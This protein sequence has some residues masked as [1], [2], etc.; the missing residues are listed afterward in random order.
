MKVLLTCNSC[1]KHKLITV[2]VKIYSFFKVVLAKSDNPI[3][4]YQKDPIANTMGL[5]FRDVKTKPPLLSL[6]AIIPHGFQI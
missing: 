3:I 5:F 6:D 4:L 1:K 2:F